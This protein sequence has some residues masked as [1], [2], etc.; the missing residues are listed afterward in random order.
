[1]AGPPP[2]AATA[3]DLPE[4]AVDGAAFGLPGPLMVQACGHPKRFGVA[5]AAPD[6]GG[7]ATAG[8]DRTAELFV[9][10][11]FRQGRVDAGA[12][13]GT[14]VLTAPLAYKTHV[15]ESADAGFA[16][17]RRVFDCGLHPPGGTGSTL[18]A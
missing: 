10:D 15:L 1:M 11:L 7:V 4:T 14:S 12:A 3:G 13:A 16:L 9:E 8:S 18:G 6:T 17:R 2:D 5:G